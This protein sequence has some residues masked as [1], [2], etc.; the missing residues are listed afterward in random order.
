M[1]DP[2]LEPKNDFK[3]LLLLSYYKNMIL[4]LFMNVSDLTFAKEGMNETNAGFLRISLT[5]TII[6]VV[7]L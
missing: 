1:F 2:F 3:S 5:L 7:A 4:H 6:I